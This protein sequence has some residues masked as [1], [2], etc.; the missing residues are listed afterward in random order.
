MAF[1]V[2][3]VGELNGIGADIAAKGKLMDLVEITP[4]DPVRAPEQELIEHY[5]I[6]TAVHGLDY[7]ERPFAPYNTYL[8]FL[9]APR[10]V[11]GPRR[12]WVARHGPRIAGTAMVELPD[13]ENRGSAIT[14]IRVPPGLRRRGLGTA[15]LGTTLPECQIADRETVVGYDVKVGGDGERW[16]RRLGFVT[17]AESVWQTLTVAGKDPARW[18]VPPPEGFHPERWTGAAPDRLV[19]RFAKARTA[20]HDAPTGQSSLGFP[21]WT[22]ERVRRH[23]AAARERNCELHTVVAIHRASGQVAG[24]TEIEIRDGRFDTAYQGDTAVLSEFRGHGLGR[25]LKATM[26]RWRLAE[27]PQL[28]EVVTRTA[29]DNRHMIRVN[30]ELG[31][32]TDNTVVN[33]EINVDLLHNRIYAPPTS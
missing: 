32:T 25:F 26:M 22:V 12:F 27:R 7:P 21:D 29:A 31:Y 30:H 1:D 20:I 10:S 9:R 5:G 14:L 6:A 18:Q 8:S 11:F 19:A 17:V 13:A 33:L 4:F 3:T 15:L 24:L 16:A 28:T 23:E 2:A